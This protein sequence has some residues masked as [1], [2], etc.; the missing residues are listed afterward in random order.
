MPSLAPSGSYVSLAYTVRALLK[1]VK[2][3]VDVQRRIV[4]LAY[5]V[6]ALLKVGEDVVIALASSYVSLAYTVRA[7]LKV[8][9]G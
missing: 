7:L 3:R 9:R 1:G 8:S 6:R 5:T 2:K 4:S